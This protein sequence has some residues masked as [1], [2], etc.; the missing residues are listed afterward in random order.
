MD[1]TAHTGSSVAE[2]R[3]GFRVPSQPT[4]VVYGAGGHAR[5]VLDALL[6]SGKHVAGLLDDVVSAG[7][8][9]LGFSVLGGQAWLEDNRSALVALGVGDNTARRRVAV[10]CERFGV[11]LATVTHPAAVISRFADLSSGVVVLAGAIVNAGAKLGVGCLVNSAAVVEHDAVVGD[12]SHVSPNSTLTGGATLGSGAQLGASAC[13]LPGI[14]VGDETVVGA[15]AV[16]CQNLPSGCV[17][18]GVPARVVR[19]LPAK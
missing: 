1:K 10:E 19:G 11:V 18:L 15:G 14:S 5:V 4:Y 9:V 3:E 13:V 16:V 8:T 12:F 17:A 7:T 6:A 2:A